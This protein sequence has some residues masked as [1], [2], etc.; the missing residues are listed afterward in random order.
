MP[1]I[2]PNKTLRRATD[3]DLAEHYQKVSGDD[4]PKA[5]R[6]EAQVLHEMQRRDQADELR[7]ARQTYRSTQRTDNDAERERVYL[8]AEAATKGNWTNASGRARGI[9]D[10]EI[11]TGREAVFRRYASDEAREYF[12]EHPRPTAAY[13]RGKDTRVAAPFS[14]T[15]KGKPIE[16]HWINRPVRRRKAA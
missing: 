5:R 10:K 9:S 14:T 1:V 11:L 13:F 4:S 3:E 7:Q 16:Q 6:A 2:L 15:K 8:D 12:G